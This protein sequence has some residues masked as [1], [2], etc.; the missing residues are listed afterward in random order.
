VVA[1][2]IYLTTTYSQSEI[3]P[4]SYKFPNVNEG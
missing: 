4:F 2:S 3:L 1:G